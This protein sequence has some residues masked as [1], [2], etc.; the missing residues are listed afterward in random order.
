MDDND[1]NKDFTASFAQSSVGS[2]ASTFR[3]RN[4]AKSGDELKK[5]RETRAAEALKMKDDQLKIL[6][7]QNSNLLESL[8]KVVFLF[9]FSCIKDD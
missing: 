9:F 7:D 5:A 3:G 4:T 6:S 8:D 2:M 1:T